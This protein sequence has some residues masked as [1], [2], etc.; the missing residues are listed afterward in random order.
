MTVYTPS[1]HHVFGELD[2]LGVLLNLS[3]LSSERN[4]AYKRR[5][6]DV[7]AN[8]ANSVY[9]G[10]INGIT[11]ELG[12]EIYQALTIAEVTGACSYPA[13][14]FDETKC[15]IYSD[16][17]DTTDGLYTT[18]DRYDRLD[19]AWTYQELIDQIN[20]SGYFT[21]QLVS[22]IEPKLRSMCI[23]N[24]KTI[25]SILGEDISTAGSVVNLENS[26]LLSSTMSVISDNLTDRV[27][28]TSE[29]TGPGKYYI[30]ADNGIIYSFEAP[31]SG[32]TIRYQYRDTTTKIYA[33]PVIIHNLQ[34]SDFKEKMFEQI[35]YNGT[36]ENGLSTDL[37]TDLLNE[38]MS[39]YGYFWGE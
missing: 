7:F 33:S 10:L 35:L 25:K 26:R 2:Q 16:Y 1:Q 20:A 22:G 39:V 32:S 29:I 13:I 3:R 31:E 8:R 28:S 38:L 18:L 6:F 21:A 9:R 27:S 17:T 15:Y 30:D 23:F 24:Q 19:D 36:Y 4:D 11:R 5:L 37:G 34:S 14:V 12:L